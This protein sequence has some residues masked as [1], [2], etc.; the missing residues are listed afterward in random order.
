MPN[1]HCF[2]VHYCCGCLG[3][4]GSNIDEA[5]V[6]DCRCSCCSRL[7]HIDTLLLWH[8]CC[9]SGT[10]HCDHHPPS[11]PSTSLRP[12]HTSHRTV[13]DVSL[14]RQQLPHCQASF[15]VLP[16]VVDVATSRRGTS[17]LTRWNK[18][19][20][21]Q[22]NRESSK[23]VPNQTLSTPVMRGGDGGGEGGVS[24]V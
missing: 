21:E 20:A 10:R 24:R 6:V 2:V 11:P 15:V 14:P 19:R 8:A 12:P 9:P 22:G 4:Y 3:Y 13:V 23:H 17:G 16:P 18:R 5:S 7:P 1:R